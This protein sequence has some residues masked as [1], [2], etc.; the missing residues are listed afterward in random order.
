MNMNNTKKAQGIID[1]F[2]GGIWYFL[3]ALILSVPTFIAVHSYI[4]SINVHEDEAVA[5][6]AT[7]CFILGIFA[8]R[9]IG[10][11]WLLKSSNPSGISVFALVFFIVICVVWIF[12]HADFPLGNRVAVNLMLFWGPFALMSITIGVFFKILH[13]ISNRQLAE[14]QR[15]AAHSKSEL[16]LLQ[17]QLSPHFLFNTL[18]NLY[19]LSITNHERIPPLLLKLSE[20]LRYAVYDAREVYVPLT[21]EIAYIRNY[22]AFE[23]LRIGDR[24]HLTT[25]IE[26]VTDASIMIAPMLLIVFIENAFKHSKNSASD[27]IY[28]DI[29]LRTWGSSILFIAKNSYSG[30]KNTLDKVSG[31]GLPNV[32][33]RLQLLYPDSHDLQIN[34]DDKSFTVELQLKTKTK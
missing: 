22:I 5:F 30:E 1:D 32:L 16:H 28:V 21:D 29:K 7:V 33:K 10:R 11:M 3:S 31:V 27:V 9:Y 15:D 8:G 23:K 2:F 18:N 13:Y 26:E 24:L 19:G 34:S 4:E 25:D 14:A 6:A 17:S 12:F 20:L